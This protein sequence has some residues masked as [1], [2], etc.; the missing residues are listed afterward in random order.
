M[1]MIDGM[2]TQLL[3]ELTSRGFVTSLED[4]STQ[5]HRADLVRAILGCGFYPLIGR[6][7]PL[8]ARDQKAR[9][10]LLTRD[11]DNVRI[12]PASTNCKL[13]IEKKEVEE[14]EEP[15]PEFAALMFYD[16]ITRGDAM[17]YVKSCTAIAPAPYGACRCTCGS[18]T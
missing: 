17:L 12:H 18:S 10:A 5:G 8:P 15:P 13:R 11:G 14:D 6:I 16:E 2:R 3:G 4:G 9:T 7:K 1:N